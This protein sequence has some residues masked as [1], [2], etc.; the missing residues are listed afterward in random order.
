MQLS[1]KTTQSESKFGKWFLRDRFQSLYMRFGKNFLGRK[2]LV[3][4][5]FAQALDNKDWYDAYR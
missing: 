4:T 2:R 5:G 1:I 3:E